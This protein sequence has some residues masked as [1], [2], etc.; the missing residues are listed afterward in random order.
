MKLNK[1][2]TQAVCHG[3]GPALVLAGPGTGKTTVLTG[4]VKHLIEEGE[5]PSSILV[6]TFTRAAAQEMQQRFFRESGRIETGVVFST[7]H[8][9][10]L[11]ILRQEC[12]Y[13]EQDVLPERERSRI[14]KRILSEEGFE[15]SEE[16]VRLA[17]S[18]I[19]RVKNTCPDETLPDAFCASWC[20]P[21]KF[22]ALYRKYNETLRRRHKISFDDMPRYCLELFRSSRRILHGWQQAW[23]YILVDEFQDINPLQYE[24]LCMLSLPED[25]F[26]A[27]GDEDQ[28]IY[29]FRGASPQLILNFEQDHPGTKRIVLETNYRCAQEIIT[30]SLK[31]IGENVLRMNK[32]I[33]AAGRRGGSLKVLQAAG[34][35]EEARQVVSDIR[36]HLSAGMPP[37]QI[38]VLYR[39]RGSAGSLVRELQEQKI[40][41]RMKQKARDF[42]ADP[43]VQDLFAYFRLAENPHSMP[44]L[45]RILNRPQ[46]NLPRELFTDLKAD[47]S[48]AQDAWLTP[49]EAR[50]YGKLRRDLE[51][52]RRYTPYAGLHYIMEAIGYEKELR[53]Q[54]QRLRLPPEEAMEIPELLYQEALKYDTF[55]AW[56][57]AIEEQRTYS[58]SQNTGS[59]DGV[60]LSTIHGAKGL[61]F[62]L[63]Y[64]VDACE[65]ILPVRAA[66]SAEQ[67]EEERRL[68]YVAMT[69]A[70]AE[71]KICTI[72]RFHAHEM[73]PSRFLREAGVIQTGIDEEAGNR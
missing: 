4:R 9:L 11:R 61:E 1:S 43:I 70:R 67:I 6:V 57:D 2:Q 69:R 71:L 7:C 64:L 37:E 54:M 46:R 36:A 22:R 3:S 41:F 31:L 56:E 42:Y 66:V 17:A 34:Q 53:A 15:A 39:S 58:T 47:G 33:S 8:A 35:E 68:C 45:L 40:A 23:K 59:T 24:L 62:D 13:S 19:S 5:K 72:S 52:L 55:R 18:E 44:D 27:V 65:N 26:F 51:R 49:E 28:S 29:A 21:E 63:V 14:L 10:F 38:A 30:P 48:F 50:E 32:T 60:L 20:T 73:Q 16:F 12:G 25:N